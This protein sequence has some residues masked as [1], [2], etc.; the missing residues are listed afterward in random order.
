MSYHDR[1]Q[2]VVVTTPATPAVTVTP[3]QGVVT[4]APSVMTPVVTTP[5]TSVCTQASMNVVAGFTVTPVYTL[6]QQLNIPD[7]GSV[8]SG[9][10][11]VFLNNM[12]SRY[13]NQGCAWWNNRVSHW[14]SQLP[15]ITNS[16]HLQLKNA[17]IAFGQQ[18]HAQCGC[19]GTVPVIPV[20]PN[21]Y[22]VNITPT[23]GVLDPPLS[24]PPKSKF[25]HN[26]VRDRENIVQ[27]A[28]YTVNNMTRSYEG[29]A[30]SLTKWP[31]IF[32]WDMIGEGE[33]PVFYK[34]VL[35]D[36]TNIKNDLNWDVNNFPENQVYIWVYFGKNETTAIRSSTILK[37]HIEIQHDSTPVPLVVDPLLLVG[38]K[39]ELGI[40]DKERIRDKTINTFKI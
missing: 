25:K 26:I 34:V 20:N 33:H 35:V 22:P 27:A 40:I 17:K 4:V 12:W 32:Q 2:N 14:Q 11:T 16:Y 3:S 13:S 36:S 38:V 15:S 21:V 5:S 37:S 7:P 8:G 28:Q 9:G 19:S 39:A 23:I 18:M 30:G 31:S 1:N 10:S 29:S 24:F 6:F